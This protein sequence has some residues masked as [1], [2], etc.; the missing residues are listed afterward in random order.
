MSDQ[1]QRLSIHY[2]DNLLSISVCNNTP[3]ENTYQQLIHSLF[4]FT[5][6]FNPSYTHMLKQVISFILFSF[7]NTTIYI[8]GSF[9]MFLIE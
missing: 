2:Q 9:V 7:T 6:H 1:N 5:D 8:M 3:I 4:V